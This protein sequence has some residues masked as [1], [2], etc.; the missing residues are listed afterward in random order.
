[1]DQA[2]SLRLPSLIY[3]MDLNLRNLAVPKLNGLAPGSAQLL[4]IVDIYEVVI[5]GS[6]LTIGTIGER[7]GWRD[8]S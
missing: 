4:W 8:Y 7:V 1:M 3:S 6:L 2:I 5:A